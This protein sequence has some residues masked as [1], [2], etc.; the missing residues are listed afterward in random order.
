MLVLDQPYPALDEERR[1]TREERERE[2]LS[3]ASGWP[4]QLNAP[5]CG[6]SWGQFEAIRN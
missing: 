1:G 5:S 6:C 2:L 4:Q 3:W